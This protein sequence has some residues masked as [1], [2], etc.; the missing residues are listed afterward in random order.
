VRPT[1]GMRYVGYL[2]LL[3]MRWIGKKTR[4]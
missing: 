3:V 4:S 1:N 2:R